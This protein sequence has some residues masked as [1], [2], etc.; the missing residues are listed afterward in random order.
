MFLLLDFGQERSVENV[1][2]LT[3]QVQDGKIVYEH[4][5]SVAM[6]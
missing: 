5:E 6:G 2:E 4:E 3:A 1:A